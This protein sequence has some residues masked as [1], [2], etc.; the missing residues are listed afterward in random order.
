MC[1]CVDLNVY[2]KM[3][4]C[5]TG[6]RLLVSVAAEA[7]LHRASERLLNRLQNYYSSMFS[8]MFYVSGKQTLSVT[9]LLTSWF[10]GKKSLQFRPASDHMA[11][12]LAG[13]CKGREHSDMDVTIWQRWL[14][15]NLEPQACVRPTISLQSSFRISTS[16]TPAS[17][18]GSRGL[19]ISL[20]AQWERIS[21]RMMTFN[22]TQ[23]QLYLYTES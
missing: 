9:N 12:T 11:P 14:S 8:V 21:V 7:A 18:S 10:S 13:V 19:E 3:L 6:G 2:F 4:K 22:V 16:R 15:Q 23:L 20:S 17:P 5:T 1:V